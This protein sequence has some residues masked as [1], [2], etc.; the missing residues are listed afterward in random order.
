[1]QLPFWS[2]TLIQSL[3]I[4]GY[5]IESLNIQSSLVPP[6]SPCHI[7]SFC[8]IHCIYHHLKYVQLLTCCYCF[9]PIRMWATQLQWYCLLC[10]LLHY[11]SLLYCLGH[12]RYSM[13]F[14]NEWIFQG[15]SI[16]CSFKPFAC[17]RIQLLLLILIS[18]Q[19][20]HTLLS[21]PWLTYTI[22]VTRNILL[23]VT[24]CFS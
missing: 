3:S 2:Y 13:I 7:T 22:I 18:F 4:S 5:T 17:L 9:S 16:R 11:Q 8:F 15:A 23:S 21:S 6:L 14:L 19:I 24:G 20:P 1:M 10:Q 12:R